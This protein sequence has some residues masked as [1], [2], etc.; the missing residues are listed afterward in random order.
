MNNE[1]I[2]E[3]QS[4]QNAISELV[5]EKRSL[6]NNKAAHAQE[7]ENMKRNA[8]SAY[9]DGLKKL[10]I[11]ETVADNEL[12][13]ELNKTVLQRRKID[14]QLNQELR[15]RAT[16]L[17]KQFEVI[18]NNDRN[19]IA[20]IDNACSE[21]PENI[22]R[23]YGRKPNAFPAAPPDLNALNNLYQSCNDIIGGRGKQ[24]KFVTKAAEAKYYLEE[25]IIRAETDFRQQVNAISNTLNKKGNASKA[26]CDSL[27]I[28]AKNKRAQKHAEI[29]Q[30]KTALEQVMLQSY[31]AADKAAEQYAQQEAAVAAQLQNKINST[32]SNSLITGFAVRERNRLIGTGYHDTDWK[33]FAPERCRSEFPLGSVSIKLNDCGA[34][35]SNY[36]TKCMSGFF[37]NSCFNIPL[38]HK[39]NSSLKMF[40]HYDSATKNNAAE[41]AQ[42]FILEKLRTNPIASIEVFFSDPKDRGQNLGLLTDTFDANSQ[43][44]IKV[45]NDYK[46]IKETLSDIV[47]QI[48]NTVVAVREY[49]NFYEYRSAGEQEI[50]ETVLVICD[51]DKIADQEMTNMLSII[52]SR[53]ELCGI[54]VILTA[55]KDYATLNKDFKEDRLSLDFIASGNSYI[56]DLPRRTVVSPQGN[57]P[58]VPVK[59]QSWHDSFMKMYR[60]YSTEGLKLHNEFRLFFNSKEQKPYLDATKALKLPIMLRN[61]PGGKLTDYTIGTSTST[62]T[63]I[64]GSIG[65]GK[66]KLLHM[67]IASVLLNYHPDDV[68]LWLVDYGKVEFEAYLR[69]RPP[70]VRFISLEKTEE[71]TYAFLEHLKAVFTQRE[72]IFFENGC[73]SL[74]EYRAK[75][76]KL[77]MPR[78]LIII[79]EMHVMT[80]HISTSRHYVHILENALT[81]Y[82]KFGLSCIFSNQTEEALNGLTQTG[83]DMIRN[84]IA[85]SGTLTNMIGTLAV[86][87]DN[88]AN[89]LAKMERTGVGEM[90]M[91]EW[92]SNSD[93][94]ISNFKAIYIDTPERD[95]VLK[96]V[97]ARGIEPK[98][99]TD[100]YIINGDERLPLP[101]AD[102]L[103]R[104]INSTNVN[105]LHVMKVAI[106]VPTTIDPYF[107]FEIK[108]KVGNNI[109]VVGRDTEMAMDMI[110]TSMWC[111]QK[112]GMRILV[113]ADHDSEDYMEFEDKLSSV[114]SLEGIEICT[115]YNDICREINNLQTAIDKSTAPGK[116]TFVVWLGYP[117]MYKMFHISKSKPEASDDHSYKE[118][119][120]EVDKSIL[121]NDPTLIEQAKMLGM[122]VDQLLSNF[123]ID[124]TPKREEKKESVGCYNA[125]ADCTTI[126]SRGGQY[127]IFSILPVDQYAR[128]RNSAIEMQ[129]FE[130]KLLM[131]MNPM[132]AVN[133]ETTAS[134]AK[135]EAHVTALYLNDTAKQSFRPYFFN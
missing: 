96:D 77:S 117:D 128:I 75:F 12:N 1:T 63:L 94:I 132:E 107:E 88:V 46:S 10:S 49:K 43:I 81:E 98:C 37:S 9:N 111:A 80:Q 52:W 62:H 40:V 45:E 30:K 109:L 101:K 11:E 16:S 90:W 105:R 25:E 114:S 64:T 29:E 50:K 97:I 134:A 92:T 61:E 126:F 41:L 86:Q 14:E 70:H 121:V 113:L 48:D 67:I 127:G 116:N 28:H 33:Y 130:H 20:W 17:Q 60:K 91:K 99:D 122:T 21:M 5:R 51:F 24:K 119:T 23:S 78:I 125:I 108:K 27:D 87:S 84:R 72:K 59:A 83:R 47:K 85:M 34:S 26:Q 32:L 69:N 68:E 44:G 73:T 65:S 66:S 57:Y 7:C 89:K 106:G 82:R 3:I 4:I 95:I 103:R 31:K 6:D 133:F 115:D 42:L 93:F 71:F 112:N 79:D 38:M 54:N 56:A 58:F 129:N 35:V 74:E 53:A 118:E 18:I 76:G 110:F 131:A 120:G 2:K 124:Q 102:I 36:L 135:L 15:N 100:I 22:L 13:N 55:S 123:A 8:Q 19:T 104:C 39:N